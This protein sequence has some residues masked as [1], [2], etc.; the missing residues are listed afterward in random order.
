[1][2]GDMRRVKKF[3]GELNL[4]SLWRI[5]RLIQHPVFITGCG[6]SGTTLLLSM[7]AAQADVFAIPYETRTYL[8]RKRHRHKWMNKIMF[9]LWFAA[10]LVK[11]KIP[12]QKR[13]WCEKTPRHVRYI[14]QILHDFGTR[15]RIIHIIR[16]GRD[17]VL[18][19]HPVYGENYVSVERWVKDV[20]AGLVFEKHPQVLTVMYESLILNP[21][22]E[23]RRI[24]GFLELNKVLDYETFH[25]TTSI[26][27]HKALFSPVQG[28]YS[29]SIGVWRKS[30]NALVDA[31][32]N[33]K[34]ARDLLK[35]LGYLDNHPLI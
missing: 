21:E 34:D 25:R 26:K 11:Q 32:I 22:K 12:A 3:F 4:V 2:Y 24:S 27:E 14:A 5:P 17:V 19:K 15:A 20:M 6:R 35:R 8:R 10:H 13:M 7:L 29:G 23:A 16:D 9:H 33:N 31:F 28:L 18:S 1:M 30:S